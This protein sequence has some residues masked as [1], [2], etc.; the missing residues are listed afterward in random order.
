VGSPVVTLVISVT[1]VLL[2]LLSLYGTAAQA[3]D[4]WPWTKWS[5]MHRYRVA[6][7]KDYT[8]HRDP[9]QPWHA[10]PWVVTHPHGGCVGV[11]MTRW[12]AR[13][14]LERATGRR[15]RDA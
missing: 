14:I 8:V 15:W 12:G 5:S 10:F 4:W 9:G 2:S 6:L 3:N 11:A 7:G 13:R 1:A